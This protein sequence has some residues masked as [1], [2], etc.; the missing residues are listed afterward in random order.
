MWQI[1]GMGMTTPVLTF[2]WRLQLP[3]AKWYRRALVIF[4]DR[5]KSATS[6]RFPRRTAL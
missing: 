3:V 1:L 4:L 2:F 5:T 6:M